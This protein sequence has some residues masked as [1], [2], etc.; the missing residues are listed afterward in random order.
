MRLQVL[1][2][3][4]EE[5]YKDFLILDGSPA[6]A[7]EDFIELPQELLCKWIRSNAPVMP[8]SL[9]TLDTHQCC[10]VLNCLGQVA[11]LK[12]LR[13]FPPCE[14]FRRFPTMQTD[15][16]GERAWEQKPSVNVYSLRCVL[17]SLESCAPQW[18]CLTRLDLSVFPLYACHVPE[19]ER[20]LQVLSNSLQDF[21]LWGEK[22]CATVLPDSKRLNLKVRS[23]DRCAA[24]Q[25]YDLA[26]RVALFSAVAR[27][28]NLRILRVAAWR[29]FA[30]EDAEQVRVVVAP[31]LRMQQLEGVHVREVTDHCVAFTTVSELPFIKIVRGRSLRTFADVT[32]RGKVDLSCMWFHSEL[33]WLQSRIFTLV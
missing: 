26:A 8:A 17:Q 1:S 28:T 20:I 33:F 24:M 5:A 29:E 4:P 2:R 9:S 27:V 3:L 10:R 12:T 19:L 18:Q 6:A 7:L 15:V 25:S 22:F 32:H 21:S 13:V 31:L 11:S 14:Y 16:S 23:E 30:G